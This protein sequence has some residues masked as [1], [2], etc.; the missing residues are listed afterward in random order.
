MAGAN[1]KARQGEQQE[2]QP[3]V[4]HEERPEV[5]L[6]PDM[7]IGEMRVRDL[8]MLLGIQTSPT[9]N[10]TSPVHKY[11]NEKHEVFDLK[12]IKI[13]K[14]EKIEKWEIK[15]EKWEIDERQWGWPPIPEPDPR[16]DEL[17]QA[18]SQLRA[19]VAELRRRGGGQ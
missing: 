19:E 3:F 16:F 14:Y 2:N 5:R 9:F 13:E 7:P 12:H 6:D 11:K 4:G 10:P 8:S 18:V 15:N 1:E 17:I